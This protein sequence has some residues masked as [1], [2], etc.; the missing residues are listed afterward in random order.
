MS[1]SS[2]SRSATPMPGRTARD[3]VMDLVRVLCVVV[4]VIGHMLMIGAAVVPGRGLVI[5]RTLLETNWIGPVTWIAQIMPLFFVVGGFVGIGAWRRI[6][7]SGGTAADFIRSRILR[8]ARPSIALFAALAVGVLVMHLTGVDPESIRLIGIGITSP[9]WFLA[10]YSFAQ[11]YLPGLATFHARAP[12]WTLATLVAT[13]RVGRSERF[14]A[15]LAASSFLVDGRVWR[16][17]E[18]PLPE[19]A[20]IDVLPPFAGG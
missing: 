10:A 20:T 4:V 11:A 2:A 19:G 12:W 8:L 14:S 13:V 17:R 3:T 16:D 6:E 1:E 15:V 5:E 7:A 9:L 18:A